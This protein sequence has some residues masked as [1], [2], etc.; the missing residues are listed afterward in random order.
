MSDGQEDAVERNLIELLLR[1]WAELAV[2]PFWDNIKRPNK[3]SRGTRPWTYQSSL[4]LD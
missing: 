2:F 4:D 3:G 1:L